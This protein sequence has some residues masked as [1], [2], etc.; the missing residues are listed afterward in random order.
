[1]IGKVGMNPAFCG[2][3]KVL[4][5]E[6]NRNCIPDSPNNQGVLSYLDIK[7]IKAID[8]YGNYTKLLM[9]NREEL[10]VPKTYASKKDIIEAYTAAKDADVVIDASNEARD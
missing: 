3:I 7:K 9:K 6:N 8:G 2:Q 10:L 1:M 4:V 5:Y